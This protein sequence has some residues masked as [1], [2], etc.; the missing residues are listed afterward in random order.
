VPYD[1]SVD[2]RFALFEASMEQLLNPDRR[3]PKITTVSEELIVDIAPKM[4]LGDLELGLSLRVPPGVPQS[5]IGDLR[6]KDLIGDSLLLAIG[7]DR[8][9]AKYASLFSDRQID[10]LITG[11]RALR[12]DVLADGG[13]LVKSLGDHWSFVETWY[14]NSKA[15]VEN[16]GHRFGEDLSEADKKAL[17]AFLATL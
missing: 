16:A 14:S 4:Q 1:P 10:E 8:L 2:G 9:R 6:H 11:L 17:T 13:G 3:I 5:A 7:E 12:Q 15:R